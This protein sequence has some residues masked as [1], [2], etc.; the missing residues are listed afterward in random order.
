MRDVQR[1]TPHLGFVSIGNAA[2]RVEFALQPHAEELGLSEDA[3]LRCLRV[4]CERFGYDSTAKVHKA[5]LVGLR[6]AIHM[7]GKADADRAE[8]EYEASFI[9]E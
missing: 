8:K 4:V 7:F 2:E 5:K 3:S 6:V 1:W 9:Q